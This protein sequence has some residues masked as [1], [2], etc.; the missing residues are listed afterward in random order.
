MGNYLCIQ[1]RLC[2]LDNHTK[3]KTKYSTSVL[4]KTKNNFVNQCPNLLWVSMLYY[5]QNICITNWNSVAIQFPMLLLASVNL[6]FVIFV[7]HTSVHIL[8]CFC[9][10]LDYIDW[11]SVLIPNTATLVKCYVGL[12]TA[13]KI[14]KVH[15]Y[16]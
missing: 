1:I 15:L 16:I 12:P 10:T 13:Q 2:Y 6:D 8:F 9:I 5:F 3:S 4:S 14:I 7:L 11:R